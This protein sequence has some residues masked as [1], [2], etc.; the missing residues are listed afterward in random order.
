M[1]PSAVWRVG[2]VVAILIG[3]ALLFTCAQGQADHAGG[4]CS[5]T[6]IGVM[7]S[8]EHLGPGLHIFLDIFGSVSAQ[9]KDQ[10]ITKLMQC[11]LL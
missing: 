4:L 3:S 7:C 6:I 8:C 9:T 2:G 10:E 1:G 5:S 11:R